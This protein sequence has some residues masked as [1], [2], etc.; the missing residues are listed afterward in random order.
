MEL[1][2]LEGHSRDKLKNLIE[3]KIQH[4]DL[5]SFK[6]VIDGNDY[7]VEFGII[8]KNLQYLNLITFH[9]FQK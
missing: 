1:L 6:R 9:F 7:K 3:E 4:R 5:D 8:T 2:I